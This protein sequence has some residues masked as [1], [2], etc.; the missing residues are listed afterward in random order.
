VYV[1]AV[2]ED[3]EIR[4]LRRLRKHV[5]ELPTELELVETFMWLRR[6]SQRKVLLVLDQFEQWLHFHAV[7]D[8]SDLVSALRQSDGAHLQ[9]ILMIRDDF[10]MA[11][12]RFMRQ[13]EVEL[14]QGKNFAAVDLFPIKHAIR[15]LAAFGRAYNCLSES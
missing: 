10:W 15:V 11:V 3:T 9:T 7:D 1:E 14:V 5:P 12:T 13:M 6:H 4:V 2:S 8:Q